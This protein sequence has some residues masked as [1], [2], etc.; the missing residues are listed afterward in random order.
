MKVWELRDEWTLEHLHVG[1]R[2]RP[3]VGPGPALL[4]MCA[5]QRWTVAD[6]VVLRRG[7]GAGSGT[8]PLIPLS[9]GVGGV[10]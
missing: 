2:P 3:Q 9:D 10:V 4:R 7:Y 1:R 6:L 5:P 8:L